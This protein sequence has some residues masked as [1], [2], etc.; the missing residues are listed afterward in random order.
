MGMRENANLKPKAIKRL[1]S[2]HEIHMLAD[3][4]GNEAKAKRTC[5][6]KVSTLHLEMEILDAEWQW[7]VNY[8]HQYNQDI[9]LILF[10][11]TSRS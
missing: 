8:L 3:K 10:A 6:N 4:E 11:G 5:Q 9:L 2:Q 7:Y 1:A